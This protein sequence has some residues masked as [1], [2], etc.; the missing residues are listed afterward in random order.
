MGTLNSRWSTSVGKKNRGQID[1]EKKVVKRGKRR[2]H[3][4]DGEKQQNMWGSK[5]A[6]RG[7]RV[8]EEKLGDDAIK[9]KKGN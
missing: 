1:Q 9:Q 8:M 2:K 6:G 4:L 7:W 5:S 3:A